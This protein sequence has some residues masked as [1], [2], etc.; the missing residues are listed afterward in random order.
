MILLSTKEFNLNQICEG[1]FFLAFFISLL[2]QSSMV[3]L[4]FIGDIAILLRFLGLAR[5]QYR[6]NDCHIELD[7]S[8]LCLGRRCQT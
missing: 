5:C 6:A 3:S 2:M 4:K 8:G 7:R 1:L